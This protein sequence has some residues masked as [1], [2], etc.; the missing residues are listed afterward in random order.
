MAR[1]QLDPTRLDPRDVE[2]VVDQREHL[3]SG[4]ADLLG[5]G[6]LLGGQLGVEQQIV[7]PDHTIH[8]RADLVA[9]RREERGLHVRR[10]DR[11]VARRR[12]LGR[13]AVAL[14]HVEAEDDAALPPGELD[15]VAGDL[16]VDHGAVLMAVA[17]RQREQGARA[18]LREEGVDGGREGGRVLLG[19]ELLDR[20]LEELLARVAV[21]G[22]RGV[23]DGDDPPRRALVGDERLRVTLEQDPVA[24]LA[25]AEL[26][27]LCRVER[28]LAPQPAT[29]R[30][31]DGEEDEVEQREADREVDV[32]VVEA[33]GHVGADRRVGEVELEH[34]N[35]ASR[36][37]GHQ[38]LVDLDRRGSERPAVVAV[39][40]EVRQVA[41]HR[42]V[43]RLDHLVLGLAVVE[44]G[45]VVGVDDVAGEV[46]DSHPQDRRVGRVHGSR[47]EAVERATL[48]ARDA[49]G[50]R[51][52][53]E[54]RLD[55]GLSDD[56]GLVA[57][58]IE[59]TAVRLARQA[60]REPDAE[61]EHG[62][63]QDRR[64]SREEAG[65]RAAGRTGQPLRLSHT[66]RI[67]SR[68]PGLEGAV[69]ENAARSRQRASDRA[70]A[71]RVDQRAADRR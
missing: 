25:R 52:S 67:G 39:R 4:A 8:R 68:R 54:Q 71:P 50:D 41:D 42:A 21:G 13:R 47:D 7:H 1:E 23:G 19:N 65:G 46:A 27:G 45:S 32:E 56:L 64:I 69:R 12:H 11:G 62:D 53:V 16:D 36:R 10:L 55:R 9:H 26:L 15:V 58:L 37:T 33:R 61:R 20:H 57:A 24:L 31:R 28:E 3:L 35:P 66:L 2:D 51:A 22:D 30:Q 18:G 14:G 29:D 43:R 17:Q 38:R 59:T 6:A 49:G 48:R 60:Q 5:V 44:P 63:E 40:V 34:A 70:R